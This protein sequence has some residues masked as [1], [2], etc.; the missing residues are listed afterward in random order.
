MSVRQLKKK[1]FT[2]TFIFL[3]APYVWPFV[4]PDSRFRGE[5]RLQTDF[6][7]GNVQTPALM[8]FL[9]LPSLDFTTPK[10]SVAVVRVRSVFTRKLSIRVLANCMYIEAKAYSSL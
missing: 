7:L 8:S 5:L 10:R 2:L 3:F 4:R 6:S 9:L 1:E